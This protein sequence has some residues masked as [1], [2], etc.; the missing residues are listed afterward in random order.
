MSAQSAYR[1]DV[2]LDFESAQQYLIR[3]TEPITAHEQVSLDQ[4][5][6][7]VLSKDLIAIA[8][9]PSASN[10]AMDGYAIRYE[11]CAKT[12]VF[13]IQQRCYAGTKPPE[14]KAGHT[15]RLFTGSVLPKGADTVVM[16]EDVLERGEMA[17]F[18][19]KVRAG[20]HVRRQGEDVHSGELMIAEGMV[21]NAAHA[22]LIAM[23]GFATIAVRRPLRIGILTTGDELVA[24][25]NPKRAE[26]VYDSN[27][28]MLSALVKGV[29]ATVSAIR[30]APDDMRETRSALSQLLADADMV[31]SAGGVSV[32]ERDFLRPALETLGGT[33]DV[34]KVR[35][36]PGKPLSVG[37]I[38]GKT[39]V[40]L[41]GNPGAVYTVFALMVTP[42]LRRLQGRRVVLPPTSMLPMTGARRGTPNRDEFTRVAVHTTIE[43][44]NL[45]IPFAQQSSGS[46]RTLSEASGLAR[47]RPG[48]DV[49]DG[50]L[51]EYFDF[52]TWL[53]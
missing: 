51:V 46:M 39:V 31:V 9:M 42:I 37:R 1:A 12:S 40:C 15:I 10:S 25:G 5:V 11:D 3:T 30:H 21:L 24:V 28:P 49:E 43:G 4:S 38:A 20:Q 50:D 22:A 47:Q 44:K 36:K 52:T 45:L 35:M 19:G 29:G 48:Q 32:G 6:G 27:G 53:S 7:R 26:Q 33:L 13:P 23:Q 41:P 8:D 14:I 18:P 16:Q 2:T 17:E 34:F